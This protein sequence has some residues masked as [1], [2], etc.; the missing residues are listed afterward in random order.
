VGRLHALFAAD[1]IQSRGR[2]VDEYGRSIS[3]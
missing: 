2:M 1:C 3:L